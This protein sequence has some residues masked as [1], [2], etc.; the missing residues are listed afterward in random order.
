MEVVTTYQDL[1]EVGENEKERLDF[2]RSCIAKHMASGE[3]KTAVDAAEYYKGKNVT[4]RKY[5]KLLYTVKGN[6]VPDNFSANHKLSSNFF[7]RFVTQQNQFLLGN[8]VNWNEK[9][10]VE[11]TLGN[12]FD[13]RLKDAGLQALI[14]GVSFLFFNLDHV[15]VFKES[16]FVPLYDEMTS[17]LRAGIRFWQIQRDKPLIATLY[18]QDGYTSYEWV[19]GDGRITAEK[20]P[21]KMQV[22]RTAVDDAEIVD[23]SN[24]E[25]FPIVPLFANDMK[26]S[27]FVGI[28]ESID[29]Y[30]L[31][32]SGF[33]NDLDDASQIYWTI[34]NAGGMDDDVSL[35]QFIE[36]MKVVKAAVLDDNARAESHTIEVPYAARKELLETL[37]KD[38]Y[39]DYMALDT[40]QIAGGAITATQI[41][42]AYEPMNSKADQYEHCILDAIYK[43]LKIAGIENENPTFTRSYLVNKQEEVQNVLNSAAFLPEDYVTKKLLTLLGDGDKADEIIRQMEIDGFDRMNEEG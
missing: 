21:Y 40:E 18:E 9:E 34:T 28:R 22:E 23:F 35:A 37:R 17:A 19:D 39:R 20:R 7:F 24:Y 30:D 25:G 16:E 14:G 38:M 42:A 3:R 13:M 26:Q 32:R 33:A 15:E 29:C 6:A 43:L 11:K 31:V 12:D 5:T 1:V 41:L 10:T 8:G 36:R 2:V 27:E 4:I